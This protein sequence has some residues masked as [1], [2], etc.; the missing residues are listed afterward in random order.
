MSE[1]N[2]DSASDTRDTLLVA[3]LSMIAIGTGVLL[4]HPGLRVQARKLL[5]GV[6]PDLEHAFA[7]KPLGGVLQDFERYLKMRSI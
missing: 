1:Y 5:L 4:A 7:N 3:G 6:M 2:G